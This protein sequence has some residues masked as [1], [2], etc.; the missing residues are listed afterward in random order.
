MFDNGKYKTSNSIEPGKGYWV[1]LE[2]EIS[3]IYSYQ[4]TQQSTSAQSNYQ[5]GWNLYGIQA[6]IPRPSEASDVMWHWTNN[7]FHVVPINNDLQPGKGYWINLASPSNL[8]LGLLDSDTDGDEI[9]DYWEAL[10]QF[11][12]NLADDMNEDPDIDNL[13]NFGEYRAGTHP[14]N[15]D[16]DAD[17]LIDGDEVNNFS[18]NP[19]LRDTDTDGLDDG[20]EI[21]VLGTSALLKDTDD[22]GF[23]DGEEVFEQS[24]PLEP[25]LIPLTRIESSPSDGENGVA[26]TRETIIRFTRPLAN[27]VEVD[28]EVFYAEFGGE[29]LSTRIHVGSNQRTMTLFYDD[30]LPPSSRIRVTIKGDNLLDDRNIPIDVDGD[31]VPGGIVNLDFETLNLTTIPSTAVCGRVFASELMA[32]NSEEEAI[33]QPLEGVTI[34]VDGMEDTLKAITDNDGNFRLEPVPSGRFFVH[35]DGRTV[36]ETL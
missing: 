7:R 17:G 15:Q 9:P 36:K 18:T 2:E 29:L 30:N 26:L 35:I 23:D 28:N 11:N 34:T 13:I 27:S 31:G 8:P 33:N 22:D 25:G 32:M 24:N 19:L 10:W 5:S 20:I 16:T 6:P 21:N 12:Y 1:Y 14:R 4:T 3:L